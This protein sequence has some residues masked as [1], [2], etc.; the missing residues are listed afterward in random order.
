MAQQT[1][2]EEIGLKLRRG[3]ETLDVTRAP[4]PLGIRAADRYAEP[5]FE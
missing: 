3:E 4:G 2:R 1:G 5:A